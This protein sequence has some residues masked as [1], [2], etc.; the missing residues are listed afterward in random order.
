[1]NARRWVALLVIGAGLV[2]LGL[3]ARREH[4]AWSDLTV[5]FPGAG[6]LGPQNVPVAGDSF[7]GAA[8]APEQ[9][10]DPVRFVRLTK[11]LNNARAVV[12][13]T[14]DD[15]T[16]YVPAA[17]EAMDRYGVKATIFV[18]TQRRPI[19]ELWPALRRA[20][21][22]GHE[23]GSHA[24][25][26]I[27]PWGSARRPCFFAYSDYELAGSRD[28]I[29]RQTPQRYVWSFAYP[30][31]LCAS[32]EFVHRKLERA[33]Y[34]VARNYPNEATGGHNAPGLETYDAN[35]YNATYTQV[36]QKK[37]GIAPSGRTDVAEVN[38]KFDEVYNNGGIY[39]FLSHPQWL[40]YGPDGFYERHLRHLAN[41]ADVWYVPMGPLYAYQR[42]AERTRVR[43]LG[44]DRFAVA[45]DLPPHIFPNSVT[46]EFAF[47]APG[48]WD[49]EANGRPLPE[50]STGLT[51]RWDQEYFRRQGDVMFVTVRPKAILQFRKKT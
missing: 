16:K 43:R 27:C 42:V 35:R 12:T 37:G 25:N 44:P 28:D 10:G 51:D 9:P 22:N 38:R 26:H 24:R 7:A 31:G 5:F 46:L 1:M 21:E 45:H 3:D 2:W 18:S 30:C 20:V 19:A 14:I 41:R 13:H 47:A 39:N 40:D 36:V 8:E 32:Y 49:V 6:P 50:R 15:S 48:Q 23:I 17:I 34:L 29:L 11:Y 33:G 4:L